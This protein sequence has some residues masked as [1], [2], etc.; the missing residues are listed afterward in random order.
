M[1]QQKFKGGGD[2]NL[3]STIK[4]AK[5]VSQLIIRKIVKISPPDVTFSS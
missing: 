4:F 1:L 5:V 3:G 2:K